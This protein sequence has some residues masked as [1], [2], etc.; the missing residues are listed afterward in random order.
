M[1]A[2]NGE[3]IVLTTVSNHEDAQVLAR[4]IVE[5]HL[6]ACVTCLNNATSF[7]RW[8]SD[9]ILEEHEEVLIIKTHRDQLL[10]LE[11]H[12]KESHPY[13]VPEFVVIEI[14]AL[15]AGYQQWLH[16]EMRIA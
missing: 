6:A 3:V 7:Y 2:A 14:N 1:E 11:A 12:F 5:R 16:Q 8:Q 13:D 10:L 4:G 9:A 15:S